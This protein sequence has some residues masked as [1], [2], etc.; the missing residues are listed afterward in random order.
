MVSPADASGIR[1][2]RPK[3]RHQDMDGGGDSDEEKVR[4]SSNPSHSTILLSQQQPL[5]SDGNGRKKLKEPNVHV[6][7]RHEEFSSSGLAKPSD[8]HNNP[9]NA[10]DEASVAQGKPTREASATEE[11]PTEIAE[12]VGSPSSI[13]SDSPRPQK[14]FVRRSL[15][16]FAPLFRR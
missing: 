8:D 2:E 16:Q 14:S 15:D 11:V 5:Q 7:D 12:G 6:V 10:S 4:I 9:N 13:S 3:Q 1:S